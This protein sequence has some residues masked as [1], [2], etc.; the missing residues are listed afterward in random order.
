M[1]I[2]LFES[3]RHAYTKPEWVIDNTWDEISKFLT[4]WNDYPTKE[5]V[6][7]FNM[8]QFN[9]QGEL[10]RKRIYENQ[11]PTEV[12]ETV[13]GTIRRCKANAELCYG[14]VLDY[15][16]KE[17]IDQTIEALKEFENVVYT[18]FRHTAETHKYRVILPFTRPLTSNQLSAKEKAISSTFQEVDH[19]SFSESQAFYLHSGPN[20]F[21]H[22]NHGVFLDPDWFEDTLEPVRQLVTAVEFTGDGDYYKE[23]L[24]ESLA[25]CSGLHYA[26][27]GT[28][29][30]VLTLVAL[31]KSAGITIDQYDML[32]WN[33]AAPD[34]QLQEKNVRTSAW[35]GWNP[36]SGIRK[37]VREEFIRAY[38]GTSGFGQVKVAPWV[39]K[40]QEL[41]EKYRSKE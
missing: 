1:I 28:Q 16:G 17:R 40:R 36:H 13:A 32:C 14:L 35:Y 6:P 29:H 12:Y 24:I 20:K 18:T 4:T 3:V 25:T 21:T 10:G 27:V 26:G 22:I 39:S 8:W 37:E 30:G 5:S 23:K 15:D 31:C 2:T 11:N 9:M 34:S 19:A 7:L 38:G 41:L 33:M